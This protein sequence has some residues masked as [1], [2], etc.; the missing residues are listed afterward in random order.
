MQLP[1][2]RTISYREVGDP[3]G[4]PVIALH[5]S[6]GSSRQLQG[7]GGPAQARG[8]RLI[9]P[10]RAGYGGSTFDPAR[11]LSSDAADN[12]ALLDHLGL[13]RVA[14]AGLSG[15]GPHALALAARHPE[16]VRAVA[17]IGGVAPMKPR[18]PSLPPDRLFSRVAGWSES[19][20]RAVFGLTTWLAHRNP[21]G[22]LDRFAKVMA[23]AD[24]EVLR[25]DP[26]TREAMLDDFRNPAPTTARAT[27]RDFALFA[28]PWD[29]DLGAVAA[30]VDVWHGDEDRN[31]PVQHGR[32][33]ARVLPD[34]ELHEIEGGGHLL[35]GQLDDVL[36]GL[37]GGRP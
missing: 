23:P 21:E 32:L 12:A 19:G 25:D 26:A 30:H 3:D 11:T 17:T 7:L 2:G 33:L 9:L 13:D 24:A 16:K 6:P 14:V 28:K 8:V 4:V 35:L 27:A 15:G 31:V 10:D 29:I 37:S 22:I 1:D 34:A 20:A 36:G 18:D 5:G